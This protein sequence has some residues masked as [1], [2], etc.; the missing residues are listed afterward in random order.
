VAVALSARLAT[1]LLAATYKVWCQCSPCSPLGLAALAVQ[2]LAEMATTAHILF[3]TR[4]DPAYL[5]P[6]ALVAQAARLTQ[7][8]RAV[9][10]ALVVT[11]L[12]AAG[13]ALS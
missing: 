5:P 6:A 1:V 9:L 2:A 3:W 10:A 12:V 11:V 13:A 8:P 4:Q 7:R